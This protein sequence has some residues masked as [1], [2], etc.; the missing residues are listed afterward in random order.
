LQRIQMGPSPSIR[1]CLPTH[2]ILPYSLI[3][4]A[5][6]AYHPRACSLYNAP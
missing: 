3:S 2:N 4:K 1:L 6:L 5:A